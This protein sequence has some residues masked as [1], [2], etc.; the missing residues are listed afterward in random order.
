MSIKLSRGN[1]N[2]QLTLINFLSN[3]NSISICQGNT[4]F[5]R[6]LAEQ[7]Y[8][9][10]S[11]S[12]AH[13]QQQDGSKN[14]SKQSLILSC[15]YIIIFNY[16]RMEQK[17]LQLLTLFLAETIATAMLV[18]LGC[19]GCVNLSSLGAPAPTFLTIV[20]GF[21]LA[22]MLIINIF[23]MISG[24]HLNPAVTLAAYVYKLVDIPVRHTNFLINLNTSIMGAIMLIRRQSY[25]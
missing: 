10:V 19:M 13:N 18:F 11:A 21:G 20:L 17:Y 7:S 3:F 24:A 5:L 14:V 23:G 9:L 8:Q 25:T 4:F 1:P 6:I 16:F 22:V 12:Q 15:Y 2:L